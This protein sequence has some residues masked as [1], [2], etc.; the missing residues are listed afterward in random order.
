MTKPTKQCM[1]SRDLKQ[2]GHQSSINL[3]RSKSLLSPHQAINKHGVRSCRLRAKYLLM[4]P[5][6]CRNVIL[7]VFNTSAQ[8]NYSENNE[9]IGSEWNSKAFTE[10]EKK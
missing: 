8:I 9:N 3:V 5:Y 7:L 6:C 10:E 4:C 1:P 2:P